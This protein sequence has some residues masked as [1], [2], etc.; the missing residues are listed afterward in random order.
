MDYVK[1]LSEQII[2]IL[3]TPFAIL[4]DV[5]KIFEDSGIDYAI[6]GAIAM[7]IYNYKRSTDDLDILISKKGFKILKDELVGKY[8]YFRKGTKKNLYYNGPVGKVEVDI[9]VE[10]DNKSGVIIPN[11]RHIRNKIGGTYFVTLEKLIEIKIAGGNQPMREYD[12]PDV[13]RLIRMNNLEKNFSNKLDKTFRK[14]YL[15]FWD[16]IYE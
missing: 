10:G 11:P 8:F 12:W 5:A 2:E 15:E 9:I 13:K 14:K 1:L 7:D 6:T 16:N 4:K 3:S